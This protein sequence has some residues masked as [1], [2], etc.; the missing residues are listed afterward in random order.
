MEIY[1]TQFQVTAHTGAGNTNTAIPGIAECLS[2]FNLCRITSYEV[3]MYFTANTATTTIRPYL[4]VIL[5]VT[6]PDDFTPIASIGDICQYNKMV[7]QQLGNMRGADP[8]VKQSC[9]PSVALTNNGFS[10]VIVR[11]PWVSTAQPAVYQGLKYW[12]NNPNAGVSATTIG[13][14]DF[15]VKIHFEFKEP[16]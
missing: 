12:F 2:L 4:P 1:T 9:S 6:D 15:V 16:K 11:S 7:T 8:A 3:S 5:S 10:N 13:K 14:V